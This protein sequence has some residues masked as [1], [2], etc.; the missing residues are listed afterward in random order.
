MIKPTEPVPDLEVATVGEN[1]LFDRSGQEMTESRHDPAFAGEAG[2]ADAD[3]GDGELA[4]APVTRRQAAENI[5]PDDP[6]TW[7]RVSRNTPCPCNS[8]RKYKHCHGK[9]T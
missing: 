7:G 6:S 3:F 9:V 1:G 4:I 8:G 2:Y 5:D